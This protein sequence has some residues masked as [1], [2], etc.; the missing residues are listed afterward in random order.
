MKM[1]FVSIFDKAVEA[2]M[3]PFM[4]QSVGQA[5]RIFEDEVSRTESELG[6][7]KE[8]YALFQ[9][10]SFNDASGLLEACEPVCLCRAHEIARVIVPISGEG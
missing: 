3:R 5:V 7:H 9:I 1:I 4:A 2:Y 10:G 6:K 8:D